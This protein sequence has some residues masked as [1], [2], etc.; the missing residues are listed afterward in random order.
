[1]KK[2]TLMLV[3]LIAAAGAFAAPYTEM[4]KTFLNKGNYIYFTGKFTENNQ[5]GDFYQVI[6]RSE[7]NTIGSYNV[8]ENNQTQKGLSFLMFNRNRVL[9]IPDA[10]VKSITQDASG[11]ISID[12]IPYTKELDEKISRAAERAYDKLFGEMF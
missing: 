3:M 8:S 1:M 7:I 12:L 6:P 2:L 10:I 4:I 11:D 5:S 9:N